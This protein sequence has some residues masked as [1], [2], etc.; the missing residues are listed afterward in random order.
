M[1]SLSENVSCL[2]IILI[3]WIQYFFSHLKKHSGVLTFLCGFSDLHVCSRSV[4][5]KLLKPLDV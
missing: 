1:P 4:T 5:M 2:A 3:Q